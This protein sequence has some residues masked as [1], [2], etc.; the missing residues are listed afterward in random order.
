MPDRDLTD[1]PGLTVDEIATYEN[2]LV[3]AE[4]MHEHFGG[5]GGLL[6]EMQE[7]GIIDQYAVDLSDTSSADHAGLQ[8][9]SYLSGTSYKDRVDAAGGPEAQAREIK[10]IIAERF[11]VDGGPFEGGG[12]TWAERMAAHDGGNGNISVPEEMEDEAREALSEADSSAEVTT[13]SSSGSSTGSTSDGGLSSR[14]LVVGAVVAVAAGAA[15]VLGG[16]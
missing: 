9:G 13:P 2:D 12:S 5:V 3:G 11:A 4:A 8:I 10:E 15:A 1:G 7:E 6:H 14:Q 16:N